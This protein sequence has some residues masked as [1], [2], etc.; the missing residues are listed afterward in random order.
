MREGEREH[1][2]REITASNFLS[3]STSFSVHNQIEKNFIP[4]CGNTTQQK[5]CQLS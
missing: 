2:S 1:T 3:S 5:K 4:D